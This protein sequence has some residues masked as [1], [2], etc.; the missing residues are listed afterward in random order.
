MAIINNSLF[1]I[2]LKIIAYL[3]YGHQQF[4][5]AMGHGKWRGLEQQMHMSPQ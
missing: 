3:Q 4:A 2:S 1:E 5:Q